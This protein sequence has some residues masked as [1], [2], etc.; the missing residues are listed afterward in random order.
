MNLARVL[1]PRLFC[2]II[3]AMLLAVS[4]PDRARAGGDNQQRKERSYRIGFHFWKP[5]KIYDEAMS[6]IRDGLEIADIRYEPIVVYS[7]QDED[8]AIK[9]LKML[10]SM[11]VDVIYSLFRR[12]RKLP[13]RSG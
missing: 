11:G 5:G 13:R 7:N 10:D 8:L 9:N 3:A 6:G 2:L 4:L 1:I 12:E